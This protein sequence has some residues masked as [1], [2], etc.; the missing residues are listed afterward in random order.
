MKKMLMAAFAAAMLGS[1]TLASAS[2]DFWRVI[3]I[4]TGVYLNMRVAPG[5]DAAVVLQ[6]PPN[7]VNLIVD[8]CEMRGGRD[9]C[10]VNA[11]G[12]HGWVAK[13]YIRQMTPTE[14]QRHPYHPENIKNNTQ[15]QG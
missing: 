14:R 15:K 5:I 9:W 7:R 8:R 3:G 4:S 11:G 13:N 12:Q 2:T 1:A 6:L 10:Y